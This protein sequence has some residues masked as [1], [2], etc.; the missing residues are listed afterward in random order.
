VCV[1]GAWKKK[2]EA[3]GYGSQPQRDSL[4]EF[5]ARNASQTL[6]IALASDA[7]LGPE[8]R[9]AFE[10]IGAAAAQLRAGGAYVGVFR[11]G[12]P[13]AE[14]LSHGKPV[15]LS[16]TAS[17]H[18]DGLAPRQPIEL[19]A[20]GK[21][22]GGRASIRLSDTE[23]GSARR[24]VKF[25]VLDSEQNVLGDASTRVANLERFH[26]YFAL[27]REKPAPASDGPP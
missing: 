1:D 19:R 26:L 11:G 10:S 21:R 8:A 17:S 24:S 15:L 9:R 20:A 2:L 4:A 18:P 14:Q 22:F 16:L 13:L 3:G 6:L 5:F 25:A 27:E 23:V 7:E 12:H